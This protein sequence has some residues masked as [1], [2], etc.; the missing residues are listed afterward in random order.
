MTVKDFFLTLLK[1][2]ENEFPEEIREI[3][4]YFYMMVYSYQMRNSFFASLSLFAIT[5]C[6]IFPHSTV[7]RRTTNGNRAYTVLGLRR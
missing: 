2:R 6:D 4:V 5:Y 3:M 7:L 1:V